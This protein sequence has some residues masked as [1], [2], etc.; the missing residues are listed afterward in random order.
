[1]RECQPK[2][3]GGLCF[4]SAQPPTAHV[5][6][7]VR[8]RMCTYA[9]TD[10]H[11]YQT[12]DITP[13]LKSGQPNL[14]AVAGA[15]KNGPQALVQVVVKF[16]GT[17]GSSPLTINSD[18]SWLWLAGDAY[19]NPTPVATGGAGL[20]E[21]GVESIDARAEPVGWNTV[22]ALNASEAARWRNATVWDYPETGGFSDV[23]VGR[24]FHCCLHVRTSHTSSSPG[25]IVRSI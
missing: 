17:T 19:F 15:F 22:V 23:I 18:S 9:R 10:G 12:L 13:F 4:W 25:T 20:R 24:L 21:S 5:D 6:T 16:T 1:M 2:G 14:L 11:R 7:S 3:T 8:A